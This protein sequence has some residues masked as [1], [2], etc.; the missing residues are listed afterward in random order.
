M[1][2]A[3]EQLGL[4]SG[5]SVL[6]SFACRLLQSYTSVSNF[7]TPVQQ[8][9]GDNT[10]GWSRYVRGVLCWLATTARWAD[11][12][13]LYLLA[14]YVSRQRA[15]PATLLPVLTGILASPPN[16][17]QIPFPGSLHITSA[18]LCFA[19]EDKNIAP[20]KLPAK[21]IKPGGVTKLAA[22]SEKGGQ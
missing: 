8:V 5:E 19:F 17:S 7:F 9:C 15:T 14:G 22:D 20:I 3:A 16:H 18:R 11:A 10:A 6:E 21:A 2:A 1:A 13:M 12:A 4:D